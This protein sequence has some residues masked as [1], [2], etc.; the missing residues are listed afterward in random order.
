MGLFSRKKESKNIGEAYDRLVMEQIV[1]DDVLAASLV[2]KMKEGSPL[3]INFE[4]LDL[5][6]ANKLLAFFTGAC[7]AI[8]GRHVKINETTYLFARTEDFADG[9]LNEFLNELEED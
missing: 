8:G 6:G 4:K 3:V 2:D 1:D 7:Y 9:S 5:M